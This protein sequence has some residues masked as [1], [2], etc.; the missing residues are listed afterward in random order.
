MWNYCPRGYPTTSGRT[1]CPKT[2]RL[3]SMQLHHR[4]CFPRTRILIS[5]NSHNPQATLTTF[6]PRIPSF[7][8]KTFER[9][10]NFH[11]CPRPHRSNKNANFPCFSLN[12]QTNYAL[13]VISFPSPPIKSVPCLCLP[14]K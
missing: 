5:H 11:A 6:L 3:I 1:S 13:L 8:F 12:P 4:E 9:S 10:F 7:P 14:E 2:N